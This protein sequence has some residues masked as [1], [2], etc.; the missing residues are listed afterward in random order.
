MYELCGGYHYNDPTRPLLDFLLYLAL[1]DNY[2]ETWQEAVSLNRGTPI[3]KMD[4]V[5][6]K[7]IQ[8]VCNI[9]DN[10]MIILR[11]FL[12]TELGSSIFATQHKISQIMNLEYVEPVIGIFKS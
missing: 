4:E 9:N 12:R 8:L 6:T 5:T 7:A 11:S 1:S 2:Q 10:Q 3:P